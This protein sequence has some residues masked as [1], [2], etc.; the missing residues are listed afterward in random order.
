M[1]KHFLGRQARIVGIAINPQCTVF[2][3]GQIEVRRDQSD[4]KFSQKSSMNSAALTSR[5]MTE[6]ISCRTSIHPSLLSRSGVYFVA[7]LHTAYW[8]E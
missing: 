7:D 1:C 5:S 2:A 6:A 4:A 8:D 3:E